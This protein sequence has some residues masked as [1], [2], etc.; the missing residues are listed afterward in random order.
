MARFRVDITPSKNI[1]L[2]IFGTTSMPDGEKM[3]VL[4]KEVIFKPEIAESVGK[5]LIAAAEQLTAQA[6]DLESELETEFGESDN[7]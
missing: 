2:R 3:D 1:A 7:D 4:Q 6:V 5:Q